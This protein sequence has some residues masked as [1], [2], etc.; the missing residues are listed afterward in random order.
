MS[1]IILRAA[2]QV[3]SRRLFST[4]RPLQQIHASAMQELRA[5]FKPSMGIKSQPADYAQMIRVRATTLA[6]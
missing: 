5:I 1:A 2:R 4:Q 6:M 3:A